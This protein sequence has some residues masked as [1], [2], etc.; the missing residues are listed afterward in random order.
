[1]Y[2]R[3]TKRRRAASSMAHGRLVAARTNTLGDSSFVLAAAAEARLLHWIR[4]SVF[5]RREASFS[6]SPPEREER[7]ESISSTKIIEGD[8]AF[9]RVKSALTN[10]SDSPSYMSMH[11]R[12]GS[13]VF[14]DEG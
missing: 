8:K 10:F 1:M 9:A 3:N 7:R 2:C 6:L 12:R 13:Y 5:K 11:T 4:N 14:R